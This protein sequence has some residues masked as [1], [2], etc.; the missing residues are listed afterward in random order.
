MREVDPGLTMPEVALSL[1]VSRS[2]VYT[3]GWLMQRAFIPV[4][5]RGRRIAASDVALYK[6]LRRT[7]TVRA[8]G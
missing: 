7:E 2:T 6:E 8:A 5:K 1:G 4:G 3:I